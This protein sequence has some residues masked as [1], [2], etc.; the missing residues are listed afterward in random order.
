MK[1]PAARR[2]VGRHAS[3]VCPP[4]KASGVPGERPY[5]RWPAA[6][7]LRDVIW[8]RPPGRARRPCCVSRR[9]NGCVE[10]VPLQGPGDVDG[11]QEPVTRPTCSSTPRPSLQ[12]A[13]FGST[14]SSS[15]SECRTGARSS[16]TGDV[17]QPGRAALLG[18]DARQPVQPR[19]PDR[20]A[21]GIDEGVGAV[22]LHE[23][24]VGQGALDRR[25]GIRRCGRG[26][27]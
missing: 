25:V 16:G 9:G 19:H 7:G 5:D 1:P 26:C 23:H 6:S 10:L 12:P 20:I 13:S 11:R 14:A 18:R 8:V 4:S 17:A 2:E 15:S 3:L 27:S 21:G 24:H 22:A